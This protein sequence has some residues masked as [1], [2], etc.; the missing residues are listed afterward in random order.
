MIIDKSQEGE[1]SFCVLEKGKRERSSLFFLLS[2]AISRNIK[3]KDG[4]FP[5]Q[6]IRKRFK[7][8]MER[9]FGIGKSPFGFSALRESGFTG[10][11]RI[12]PR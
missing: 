8:T 2:R 6:W 10:T 11:I 5:K 7:D 9:W 3:G 12:V 4:R 1:C